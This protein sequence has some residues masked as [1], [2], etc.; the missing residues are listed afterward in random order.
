M[1]PSVAT[2]VIRNTRSLSKKLVFKKGNAD[3]LSELPS[4]IKHS[5]NT[6]HSSTK[7]KLNNAS[8]EGNESLVSNSL[9]DN[10]QKHTP[11]VKLGFF[12]GTA[13]N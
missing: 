4:V 10:R 3:W 12:G 6:N 9:K 1:G 13:D 7:T 5:N 2:R 11:L 8:M